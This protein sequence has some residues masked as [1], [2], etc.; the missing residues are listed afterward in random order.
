MRV[1]MSDWMLLLSCF[2]GGVMVLLIALG[3]GVAA[4]LPGI[5]RWSRRFFIV[6]FSNLVLYTIIGTVD[7]L[8]FDRPDMMITAFLLPKSKNSPHR[9]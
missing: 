9:R 6:Y 8:T 1:G 4:V 2:V 3:L 7:L 5:D